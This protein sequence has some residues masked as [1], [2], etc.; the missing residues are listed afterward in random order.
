MLHKHNYIRSKALTDAANGQ[1]CVRCG[2][3]DGTVV[4]AHYCGPLQQRLGK[5]RGIKP[6]DIYCADLCHLCHSDFDR[7]NKDEGIGR[8]DAAIDFML[9]VLLTIKRRVHD[10]TITVKGYKP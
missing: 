1:S 9:Y 10:G 7:Y 5:G 3:Q 8:Q 2:A 4:A 6:D